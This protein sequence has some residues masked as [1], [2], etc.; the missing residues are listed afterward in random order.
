MMS[1]EFPMFLAGNWATSDEKLTIVNPYSGETVGTTYQATREQL[2]QAIE[3][4]AQSFEVLRTMPTYDRVALLSEFA[5]RMRERRDEVAQMITAESGKPIKDA[6]VEADRGVFTIETAAEEA[7]RIGGEVM[8][9]DLLPSSKGRFGI[10]RRFPVGPIAGISP[11]NFPLNLAL[12]KLAPALASGN[13]IVLKPPSRDPLTMLLVA[14]MLDEIGIPE[15]AVSVLPMS[16]EVGD[17]MVEDDRFKLLS[18]TGSPDVGWEMKKRAGR[19]K[20]VLELGGNAGV[21]IDEDADLDFAA[22]RVRTGAFSYAGQVCISVQRVYVVESVYDKFKQKLVE[23]TSQ[24]VVGDPS[25]RAT[26]LG[27]MIDEKAASRSEKWI[28]DAVEAGA[29]VVTGGKANGRFLEPTIIEGASRE[30]FVCSR[31]AFAPLVNLFPVRSFGEAITQVND[32][33]FGLQAGIFTNKLEHALYAFESIEA[34]GIIMNDIPTYRI[35]HMP[36]GGIKDSG[37]SREGLRYAIEDMTEMRLL[38]INR[39]E[40]Q[41]VQ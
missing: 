13:P 11:F 10:V 37:L 36:Y 15:G 21:V 26:D 1:N 31:E 16:R 24:L 19:K 32:S 40:S 28:Q 29:T 8:P 22:Q 41:R 38:V 23:R 30:S 5:R 35:D 39:L 20:V 9:L 17:A 18:F 25:D 2:D 4:A 6:E 33:V 12:H 14:Q 27:P 7:K 3:A 34:G